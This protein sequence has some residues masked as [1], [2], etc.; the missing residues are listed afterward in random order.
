MVLHYIGRSLAESGISV[1]IISDEIPEIY[2]NCP[3]AILM[4]KGRVKSEI[5]CASMSEKEFSEVI[6]N[7]Q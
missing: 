4:H 6:V 7:A 5:D 2:Y 3:R 1:I